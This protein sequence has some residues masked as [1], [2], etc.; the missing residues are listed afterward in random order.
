MKVAFIVSAVLFAFGLQAQEHI[1]WR[2]GCPNAFARF[3]KSQETKDYT[4]IR[5]IGGSITE[6]GGAN[7]YRSLTMKRFRD[8]FPGAT[9]AENNAAIGGTGSWLGAFRT[10]KDR[11]DADAVLVFVEFAVNDGGQQEADVIASM[12]GIVR[13]IWS[14]NN[15]A[16]IV[17]LY[18]TAKNH[19][20]SYKDG[21][22]P[23]TVQ[24]HEKVAEHYGIPS[25]NMGAF[26]AKKVLDG[27]L[28]FEDFAA[29]GVHPTEK[30]YALYMEALEP[31]L[32]KGK[33]EWAGRLEPVRREWN[34]VTPLSPAPME[35]A[36]CV[37]YEW[38]KADEGWKFGQESQSS[39]FYHVATCDTPGAV[40]SFAFKGSQVGV[41]NLI[42]P[43]TGNIEYSIDNGD[44]QLLKDFDSYCVNYMR[45]HSR[46]LVKGLD[47]T[48]EHSV[49][50]RVAEAIPEQS[51]GRMVAG[52]FARGRRRAEPLRASRQT[53]TD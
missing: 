21:K 48:Q 13:R 20:D 35:K 23:P 36:M 4:K 25:V 34:K 53:R 24:Y 22:L 51:K 1:V 49:R 29:D 14:R 19:L 45:A 30:G 41:F 17:F 44:W 16:D 38:G 39:H 50:L 2:E 26:V 11:F 40:L 46:V 8:D 5:F 52:L 33:A 28:A 3:K 32:V 18:T 9:L 10:E 7:G 15:A 27:E 31:F 12:E 6:G 42:G 47:P 43:D 37:P